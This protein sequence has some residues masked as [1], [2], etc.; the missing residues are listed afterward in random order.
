MSLLRDIQ[1]GATGTDMAVEVL[2]RHCLVL[3]T[4]LRHDPLKEWV[5][6][7]LDG[8]P[9]D[10]EVPPYRDGY[11]VQLRGNFSNGFWEATNQAVPI[12]ALHE[13]VRK[14][15]PTEWLFRGSI[16]AI[17]DLAERATEDTIKLSVPPELRGYVRLYEEMPCISLWLNLSSMA[18]S[19]RSRSGPESSVGLRPRD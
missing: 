14:Y 12:G 1:E 18:P 13:D 15:V 11:P 17:S 10:V 8:Y 2:L 9:D 3:A 5:R 6:H 7:E 16:S 4:R 19:E